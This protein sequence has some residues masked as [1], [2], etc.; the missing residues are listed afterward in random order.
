MTESL[1]IIFAFPAMFIAAAT[2]LGFIALC[3]ASQ[4]EEARDRQR[5]AAA[6]I[7]RKNL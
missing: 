3:H 4:E 1:S 2:F 6:S 7:A 5:I